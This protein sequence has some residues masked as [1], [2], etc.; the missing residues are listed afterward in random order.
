MSNAQ[1]SEANRQVAYGH[2]ERFIDQGRARSQAAVE[3]VMTEVPTDRVVRP[4]H[5]AF[6]PTEYGVGMDISGSPQTFALHRN[7]VHQVGGRLDIPTR[8]MDDLSDQGD[9]G[10]DLLAHNLNTLMQRRFAGEQ[11]RFLTREHGGTVK[12]FLSDRYRRMDSRPILDSVIGSVGEAGGIIVDGHAGEVGVHVKA[13]L[14]KVVE[15]I[16]GEYIVFGFGWKNSDYGC[17]AHELYS[18]IERLVCLNGM[19]LSVEMRKVHLGSRLDERIEYSDRTYELDTEAMAAM[20]KD[21]AKF[22]LSPGRVNDLTAQ[23]RAANENVIDPRQAVAALRKAM[24][25]DETKQVVDA[26]NSPDVINL[27]PGQTSWRMSNAISWIANQTEDAERA[28][29]LQDIAG[30]TL[31]RDVLERAA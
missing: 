17:G 22:L 18:F 9:W 5:V 8:F 20:V 21:T 28:L 3:Q 25:K 19:H 23:L 30:K 10:R 27:P 29:E 12:A 1:T 15:P 13:I 7:A 26:F 6:T 31:Q 11:R 16:P 24:T 2:L 14:P 4:E